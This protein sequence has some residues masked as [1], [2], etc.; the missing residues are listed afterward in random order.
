[1]NDNIIINNINDNLNSYIDM[2][3]NYQKK[4]LALQQYK[5]HDKIAI[6]DENELYIQSR[7]PWRYIVRKIKNQ[8]RHIL[9]FYLSN[10]I[11]EYIKILDILLDRYAA[12]KEEVITKTLYEVV[13]FIPKIL[14]VIISLRNY[15][16]LKNDSHHISLTL[17]SINNRLNIILSKIKLAF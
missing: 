15:Y 16:N 1:M 12:N 10:I 13:D 7:S 9:S 4:L 3:N 17:E 8:N 11:N 5:E 6:N 14:W 2:I